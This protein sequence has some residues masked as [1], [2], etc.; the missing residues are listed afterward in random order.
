L[1][2]SFSKLAGLGYSFIVVTHDSRFAYRHCDRLAILS[3]GRIVL[4]GSPEKVFENSQDYG[5]PPPTEFDLWRR[6]GE[7]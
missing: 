2:G 4:E 1:A 5:V 3:E 7:H 6:L